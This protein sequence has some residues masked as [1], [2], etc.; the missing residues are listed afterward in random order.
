MPNVFRIYD[1]HSQLITYIT[2]KP[3]VLSVFVLGPWGDE[4]GIDINSALV[5]CHVSGVCCLCAVE[6]MVV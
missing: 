3:H 4:L 2:L 6:G 5:G 1:L